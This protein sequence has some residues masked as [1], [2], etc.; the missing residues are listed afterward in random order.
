MKVY[1]AEVAHPDLRGTL[2][3]LY[4]IQ[5]A[6]GLLLTFTLGHFIEN[7]TLYCLLLSIPSI[8]YF[9]L[10]LFIPESP[11][12]LISKDKEE[13]AVKVLKWLRQ[14]DDVQKEFE[15]IKAKKE[16]EDSSPRNNRKK[17]IHFYVY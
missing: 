12:W 3:A 16:L 13:E 11:F 1:N 9:V 10:S 17:I 7:F 8:V 6:L 15:E 5:L 4:P 2:S 14:N